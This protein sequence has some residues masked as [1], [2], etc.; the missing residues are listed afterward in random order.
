MT[1]STIFLGLDQLTARA[2]KFSAPTLLDESGSEFS[3]EAALAVGFHVYCDVHLTLPLAAAQTDESA[4]QYVDVLAEY[5]RIAESAAVVAR[6]R[7][8]E[9]QGE[10]IHLLVEDV[11]NGK[12]PTPE[13]WGRLFALSHALVKLCYERVAPLAGE[14]W[15]GCCIAADFGQAVILFSPCGGGSLVSLGN[16]ANRPAKRLAQFPAV[17]AGHLAIPSEFLPAEKR[18]IVRNWIELDV[19]SGPQVLR[20]VVAADISE[21]MRRYVVN[22][23]SRAQRMVMG[24]TD[25]RYFEQLGSGAAVE[26]VRVQGF[27]FRADL[28]GFSKQ[29]QQAFELGPEAIRALVDR[30]QSVLDFPNEFAK[31][32]NARVIPL[33]W[34][35]DCATVL[36]LPAYPESFPQTQDYLPVQASRIWHKSFE[37]ERRFHD[38]VGQA[39][40]TLGMA[41]GDADEGHS[42][43]MLLANLPAAGRRFRVAAGW[44]VRRSTDGC[45][46]DGVSGGD[47]VLTRVDRNHLKDSYAEHFKDL[48]TEFSRARSEALERQAESA[49]NAGGVTLGSKSSS[50][51]YVPPPRPYYS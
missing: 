49:T 1:F 29:V 28:D 20:D 44:A 51:L 25:T 38:S 31:R 18:P 26:P 17:P 34:A 42:G 15:K 45:Q 40:W 12:K 5:A 6:A 3:R 19:R 27:C 47:T 22:A 2:L 9:V 7:L 43:H 48:G 14:H 8:L 4:Q 50:G 10:R 46:F 21:P 13:A 36:L 37:G 11:P 41:A 33:P 32:V 23:T 24:A 35:G 30:F 39:R 16:A